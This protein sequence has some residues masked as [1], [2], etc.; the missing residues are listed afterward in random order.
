[1]SLYTTHVLMSKIAVPPY[2]S[3]RLFTNTRLLLSPSVE[4]TA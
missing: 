3:V 4:R 1:M 2:T